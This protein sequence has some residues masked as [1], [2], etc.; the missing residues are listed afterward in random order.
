[1]ITQEKGILKAIQPREY[2]P[3]KTDVTIAAVLYWK[4]PEQR[5][6]FLIFLSFLACLGLTA[7][8]L[9]R[10]AR[11]R[12]GLF[13]LEEKSSPCRRLSGSNGAFSSFVIKVGLNPL[14]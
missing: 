3:K 10:K 9:E 11:Q 14:V 12:T 13:R 1:V 6:V 4:T 8:H 7:S 5:W 2:N